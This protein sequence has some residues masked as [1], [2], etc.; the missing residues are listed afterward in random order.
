VTAANAGDLLA[1]ADGAIVGTALKENGETTAPVDADRVAD[2][3][4]AVEG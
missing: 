1:T 3:V 4:A 2:L